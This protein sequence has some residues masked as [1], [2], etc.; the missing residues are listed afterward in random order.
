MA[1]DIDIETTWRK[2]ARQKSSQEDSE[3]PKEHLDLENSCA[4]VGETF[5]L[6]KDSGARMAGFQS[7][8]ATDKL[9]DLQQSVNLSVP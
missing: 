9:C 1:A 5:Q 6:S 7:C 8:S 3:V 2:T 4:H